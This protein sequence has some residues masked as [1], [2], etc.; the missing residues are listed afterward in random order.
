MANFV[1][2]LISISFFTFDALLADF[3]INTNVS[4]KQGIS[5]FGVKQS[6]NSFFIWM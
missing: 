3:H 1:S 4:K 6:N 2:L 5:I